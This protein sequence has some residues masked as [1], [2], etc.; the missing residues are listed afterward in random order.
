[1][2]VSPNRAAGTL[3]AEA[4]RG[5]LQLGDFLHGG[6]PGS[7]ERRDQLRYGPEAGRGRGRDRLDHCD[8]SRPGLGRGPG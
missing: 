8:Y 6:G 3:G 4:G 2:K 5:V 7:V 1:M